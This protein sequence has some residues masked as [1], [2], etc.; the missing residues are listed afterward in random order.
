[1]ATNVQAHLARS[2]S[3]PGM[4][5]STA[6][7]S[8]PAIRTDPARADILIVDDELAITELITELLEDEGYSVRV[9]HDGASALLEIIRQLPHLIILDIGLPVM[10]GEELLR[11]IRQRGF[12]SVPIIVMSAGV[13][14]Q[15]YL[16]QGATDILAKPFDLDAL[17][18]R[19]RQHLVY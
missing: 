4:H 9:V 19:V 5:D 3:S 16:D 17:L 18:E 14:L 1:M 8:Q 12:T 13:Q 10:S 15:Q 11:L 6:S 7:S 2:D